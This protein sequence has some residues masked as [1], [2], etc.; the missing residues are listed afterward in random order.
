MI[1]TV[2][3][4]MI[5]VPASGLFRNGQAESEIGGQRRLGKVETFLRRRRKERVDVAICDFDVVIEK[6]NRL[7]AQEKAGPLVEQAANRSRLGPGLKDD[8]IGAGIGVCRLV[9]IE[10]H[11]VL[12][13][14]GEIARVEA[15]A[16]LDENEPLA[17]RV[18]RL[19][20][21]SQMRVRVET[22]LPGSHFLT[23]Q[24]R[25]HRAVARLRVEDPHRRF[26]ERPAPAADDVAHEGHVDVGPGPPPVPNPDFKKMQERMRM[27][28]RPV[29]ILGG[30]PSLIELR[31]RGGAVR[32]GLRE[33]EP[34]KAGCP[35]V[36]PGALAEKGRIEEAVGAVS[37]PL[38]DQ[39]VVEGSERVGALAP[40][41]PQR[42]GAAP[43]RPARQGRCKRR[44]HGRAPPQASTTMSATGPNVF[45][46]EA[47][48][49]SS[50][51]ARVAGRPRSARLVTP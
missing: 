13:R 45:S 5:P 10:Q 14:R 35:R 49:V 31:R 27:G 50:T 30:V 3:T 22:V 12:A 40:E 25:L 6:E 11:V 39:G 47:R 15:L 36:E 51:S 28:A 43:E 38:A 18:G 42:V 34:E 21:D 2:D 17:A 48:N 26:L 8:R 24:R 37:R 20:F 23:V 32:H 9:I 44:P 33:I 16:A 29:G 46:N 4:R 7:V 1:S 19:A 41:P